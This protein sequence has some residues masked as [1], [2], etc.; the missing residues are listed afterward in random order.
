MDQQLNGAEF[1]GFEISLSVFQMKFKMYFFIFSCLFLVHAALL[2]VSV[3]VLFS[4]YERNNLNVYLKAKPLSYLRLTSDINLTYK[5]NEKEYVIPAKRMYDIFNGPDIKP[6][7]DGLFKKIYLLFFITSFVYLFS[8]YLIKRYRK[9]SEDNTQEK[10]IRGSKLIDAA[11][12]NKLTDKIKKDL[13]FG[14]VKMPF[15]TECQHVFFVGAPGTGKTVF[16]NQ[17]IK[18]IIERQD[19]AIIYDFKGDFV[20]KFYRPGKDYLFNPLDARCL[21]WNLFNEISARQDFEAVA[22][23]LIPEGTDKNA[24]WNNSARDVFLSILTRLYKEGRRTHA[25]IWDTVKMPLDKLGQFISGEPGYVYIQNP[26]TGQAASTHSVMMQYV[27]CFEYM[28]EVDG[29]FSI[30]KWFREKPATGNIF[31]TNYADIKDTLKPILTLFIDLFIRQILSMPD[32]RERRVFFLIDE[33]GTL[34]RLQSIVN[35][36]TLG[37]S[38]GASAW[39]GIQDIGQIEEIYGQELRQTLINACGTNLIYRV[40]D[41]VTAKYLSDKIGERAVIETQENHSMGSAENRDGL[42][43]VRREKTDR[44]VLPSELQN[45]PDLTGYVRFIGYP[46]LTT[47]FKYQAFETKNISFEPSPHNALKE[48]SRPHKPPG[49]SPVAGFDLENDKKP[50]IPDQGSQPETPKTPDTPINEHTVAGDGLPDEDF[51]L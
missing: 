36:L 27:R 10:F 18:R 8:P 42:S 9:I 12:Y 17:N 5:I 2:F 30:K 24:F 11:Q 50:L 13:P 35:L 43:L 46:I 38:K 44:L 49:K 26:D 16:L 28:K 1:K 33:F 25:D 45:L 34:Q 20:S 29:D 31:I 40:S 3:N 39:L 14:K 47:A 22:A 23:S 37:R 21:Q 15:E 48:T 4:S 6:E 32:D 19:R 41:P 7:I 51:L